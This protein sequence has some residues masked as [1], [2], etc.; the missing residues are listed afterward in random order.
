MKSKRKIMR[1]VVTGGRDYND[2][3][4][5]AAEMR[6]LV[7]AAGGSECL[8]VINGG[9]RGLDSLVKQWCEQMGVPCIT[10]F[11][12]WDS[13]YGRGAG[14]V[15]NQWMI[16]FCDP[17]YAV[18]FPGGRGT[19]DMEKRIIAAGINFHKVQETC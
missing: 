2:G 13:S 18:V 6:K 3:R 8:V 10:M 5:V 19:A 4:T 12:P 9:A 16:D 1:V 17:T 14:P 7:K 15:R 11:A